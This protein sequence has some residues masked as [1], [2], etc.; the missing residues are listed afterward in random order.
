VQGDV[1]FSS[2]AAAEL[3]P[4]IRSFIGVPVILADDTFYGTLCAVDP[5]TQTLSPQQANLLVVLARL[6]ATQ[7]ER[8]QVEKELQL[9][10]RAIAA[11]NNGIL[12]TD[13]NLPDNPII[14]SN[15][16][17]LHIT[18]Y[19]EDELI[20]RNC[21]L[22]QDQDRNQPELDKLRKAIRED[23]DCRVLLRNY[24]KDGTLFWN[25]L[26][27]SPVY[28]ENGRV[29]N[30]IGVQNDVTERKRAEEALRE[31]ETALNTI[32]NNLEEGVLVTDSRGC[33]S[34]ANS[35]AR[36][37][38]GTTSEKLFEELPNPWEDFHLPRAVAYC[39]RNRESV[40]ARVSN[41]ESYFRVRLECLAKDERGDVLMVI[42][43]LS[44]GRR[45]EANQQRFLANA[46]HQLSTPIMAIMGA[47]EL[48]A[49]GDD[50]DPTTRHRFLTHI[51]SESRRMQRLSDALLRLARVGWDLRE[52][53]LDV[54]DLKAA[55]HQAAQAME[56]LIESAGLRV[57]IEGEGACVRGDAEWIN[58]ILVILLSNAIKHSSRGGAVRIRVST[59]TIIVE[60]EGAGISSAELPHI[61]ERFYRG[62]GYSEGFGLGLS[63]CR[64]LIERMGGSISVRSQ[65]GVGTAVQVELPEVH[66][67]KQATDYRV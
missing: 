4:G 61:F 12:I 57:S 18:G 26:S 65:E 66:A 25:E 37:M 44:E 27:V 2:H 24:R 60:D 17:V 45:L 59:G 21:R 67:G 16:S 36:A 43:D 28:D 48:L 52:P 46:A 47:A 30:H 33:V 34:F 38:L 51:A 11:S 50:A 29:I 23:H 13:P 7:I 35:S 53:N 49:T 14:Y 41:G 62:E 54:V 55:G 9:R 1:E 6:L 8:Q 42:Q 3:S 31:S 22:L 10:N 63:I 58:E 15:E 40:E 19:S 32:L 64:E 5:E 56:L 39:A 20:G